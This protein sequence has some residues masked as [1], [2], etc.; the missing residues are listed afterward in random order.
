MTQSLL[1]R[2]SALRELLA[3]HGIGDHSMRKLIAN[4]RIKRVTLPLCG[5]RKQADPTSG[6]GLYSR[7]QVQRDILDPLRGE[8]T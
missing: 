7:A 1:L 8:E 4:G 2:L 5:L 6:R 3:A